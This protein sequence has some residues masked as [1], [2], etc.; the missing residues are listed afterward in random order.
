MRFNFQGNL[1]HTPLKDILLSSKQA[2][3]VGTYVL[4]SLTMTL[5]VRLTL[6]RPAFSIRLIEN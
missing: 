2:P 5:C 4:Y 3:V 1:V 6:L